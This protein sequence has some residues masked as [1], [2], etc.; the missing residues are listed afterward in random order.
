MELPPELVAI[1]RDYS[2]PCFQHYREYNRLAR[3]CGPM[4]LFKER[5][6]QDPGYL[7]RFLEYEEALIEW[8]AAKHLCDLEKFRRLMTAR[9]AMFQWSS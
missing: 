5:L 8:R 4:P 3:I 6:Q 2:R 9:D 1:I 7:P